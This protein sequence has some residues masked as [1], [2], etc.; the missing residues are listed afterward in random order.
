LKKKMNRSKKFRVSE[1][2]EEEERSRDEEEF[3]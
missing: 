2:E 3:G 1:E